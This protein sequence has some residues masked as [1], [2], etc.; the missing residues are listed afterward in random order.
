VTIS[1]HVLDTG[2]GEPARGVAVELF[3]GDDLVASGET[4]DDGR[5]AQ[6][7]G[8]ELGPGAYRLVFHP[9]SPFFR[10]VEVEVELGPGH[11]HV[12]LLLAPYSCA[13]YRGS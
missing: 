1:T 9:S 12:P 13:I 7:A 5:I 8:D 2:R 11:H 3:R 10:R 4:D 6:L